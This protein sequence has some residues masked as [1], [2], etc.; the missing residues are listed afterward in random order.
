MV[1]EEDLRKLRQF[2][3]VLSKSMPIDEMLLF[4]SRARGEIRRWSDYD[5][6]VVSK[7]FEGEDTLKR[8]INLY[9]AWDIQAPVD[10]ICYTPDEFRRL[11]EDVTLAREAKLHGI[12][13]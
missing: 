11:S 12:A 7:A 5:L 13:I 4:G 2:K 3:E 10:F 6:M 8:P 9:N 1:S